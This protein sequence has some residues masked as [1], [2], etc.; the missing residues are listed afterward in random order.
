MSVKFSAMAFE[1]DIDEIE[2]IVRTVDVSFHEIDQEAMLAAFSDLKTQTSKEAFLLTA[3]RTLALSKNGH[4]RIIPNHVV[5]LLPLRFVA[6]GKEICLTSGHE[7]QNGQKLRSVNGVPISDIQSRFLPYLAGNRGREAAI[8]AMLLAWPTALQTINVVSESAITYEF[9]DGSE[10]TTCAQSAKTGS[11]LYPTY[12]TGTPT[13]PDRRKFDARKVDNALLITLPSFGPDAQVEENIT[14]VIEA[15]K[16]IPHRKIILDLRGNQGGNFFLSLPLIDYLEQQGTKRTQAILVDKFTFSA[17]IV[18][19]AIVH[20]RL[21][22]PKIIGEEMGD[23]TRFYAEG[24]TLTLPQTGALLRYSTVYHNWRDGKFDATTPDAI[25]Q[26]LVAASDLVPDVQ[27]EIK[28]D[29][30][31]HGKDACLEAALSLIA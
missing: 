18:F 30:F 7:N 19:V 15:I 21:G 16:D 9:T 4:T 13:L 27:P 28:L 23:T 11:T 17:A 6:I 25:I 5:P 10:I 20:A 2:R 31:Q 26:H 14:A 1:Q 29:D 3:M 8:G 24:D 12:E 22:N